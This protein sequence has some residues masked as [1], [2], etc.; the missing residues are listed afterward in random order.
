MEGDKGGLSIES[1]KHK[2]GGSS[3][4]DLES[5]KLSN[6]DIWS[7]ERNLL[8]NSIFVKIRLKGLYFLLKGI[9]LATVSVYEMIGHSQ[10]FNSSPLFS[11]RLVDMIMVRLLIDIK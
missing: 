5:S 3:M 10:Y 4:W 6:L 11:L 9:F 7:K 8:L 2:E 1:N